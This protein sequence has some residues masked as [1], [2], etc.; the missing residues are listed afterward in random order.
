M[1]FC[2]L[3]SSENWYVR[4]LMRAAT[5]HSIDVRSFEQMEGC[6][7][8]AGVWSVAADGIA[9][10]NCDAIFVRTMPLGSL[11]QMVVRIDMLHLLQQQG[12][13]IVNPPRTLEIA[14]DKWLTLYQ[15]RDLAVAM[16]ATRVCQQRQQAMEAF[17]Q[18]GRDVVV[19]P[20]FGGEG[21]G[22]M[23]VQDPDLAWRVFSALEQLRQVAYV[24]EFVPHFGYDLRLLAIGNNVVA[25]RR[26]SS[27]DW[28]TNVSRGATAVPVEPTDQQLELVQQIMRRMQATTLGIDLLPARN[29]RDY[30]LEVNAVPGWKGTAAATGVDVGTMMIAEAVAQVEARK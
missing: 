2:I 12:V 3:G 27:G 30:L 19:K 13:Q 16:P 23:R 6:F 17:E 26:E 25:V 21:R 11:E 18:L 28:R 15:L 24:Q 9:L 20:I 8:Q 1:K 22:I 14:I 10:E 29:G 7:S 4:D 5:G